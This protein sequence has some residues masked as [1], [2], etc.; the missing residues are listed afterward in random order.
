MTCPTSS[1]SSKGNKELRQHF[2]LSTNATNNVDIPAHEGTLEKNEPTANN[3]CTDSNYGGSN[4]DDFSSRFS[5][6][7]NYFT[8]SSSTKHEI[9][10]IPDIITKNDTNRIDEEKSSKNITATE[11]EFNAIVNEQRTEK[12]S[13]FDKSTIHH[14]N[15]SDQNIKLQQIYNFLNQGT[16]DLFSLQTYLKMVE[17]K[18]NRELVDLKNHLFDISPINSVPKVI[19]ETMEH[20]ISYEIENSDT[21]LLSSS[22]QTGKKGIAN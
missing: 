6:L 19:N 10:E 9:L 11:T 12:I 3:E 22:N 2:A 13:L 20:P 17:N 1:F 15:N 21:K 8:G 7:V 5:A 18:Q 16:V 4:E 14:T